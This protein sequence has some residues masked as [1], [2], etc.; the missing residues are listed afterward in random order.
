MIKR[1]RFLDDLF[2][3]SFFRDER[4]MMNIRRVLAVVVAAVFIGTSPALVAQQN[5]QQNK[6]EQEKRSQQEQQDIQ[7]LVKLVDAVMMGQQPAPTDIGI[8][9]ASNHFIKS[10]DTSTYIPFNLEIDKSKLTMPAVAMWVRAVKKGG[11]APAPAPP[12]DA[13]GGKN[14]N[15]TEQKYPWE[16]IHFF[17]VPADGKVSRAMVLPPG[18]YDVYIAVKEKTPEKPAKNAPPAKMGVV[19][20]EISVPNFGGTELTTS[21]VFVASTIDPVNPPLNA[22]QQQENPYTIGGALKVVPAEGNKLK[23]T[24]ELGVLF[25]TYGTQFDA[26]NKPD[27]L[28]E[29]AFYQKT[30]DGEKY[31]NKTA[32]QALNA[33]TLPPAFDPKAGYQVMGNLVVPLASFPAGDYRLEIKITDKLS[34]KTLTQNAN[35]TVES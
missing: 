25:W 4:G 21:S 3:E 30:A 5:N 28:I 19:K 23:K 31:F 26:M 13:K 27:V 34:S 29:Y 18:D 6:K 14:N 17:D 11:A 33:T 24:G 35:F 16:N 32:P 12:A 8:K 1:F 2:R 7:A 15:A 22:Q 10:A 20:Q 9:W